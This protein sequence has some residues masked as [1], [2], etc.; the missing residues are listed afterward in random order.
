MLDPTG[1]EALLRAGNMDRFTHLTIQPLRLSTNG[2]PLAQESR[3]RRKS[4]V[5]SHRF[6]FHGFCRQ[7]SSPPEILDHEDDEIVCIGIFPKQEPAETLAS[8]AITS[9][10]TF[11]VF[12]NLFPLSPQSRQ[13]L[14][15]T[16]TKNTVCQSQ[17]CSSSTSPV[18]DVVNDFVDSSNDHSDDSVSLKRSRLRG[19]LFAL[20][21]EYE[22]IENPKECPTSSALVTEQQL[23][24][25]NDSLSLSPSSSQELAEIETRQEK[26]R[27]KLKITFKDFR[28]NKCSCDG[29]TTRRGHSSECPRIN[30]RK[31]VEEPEE[32]LEVIELVDPSDSEGDLSDCSSTECDAQL[33][34]L[35]QNLETCGESV[36]RQRSSPKIIKTAKRKS[37]QDFF[38]SSSCWELRS[39]LAKQVP[40]MLFRYEE[41]RK[42][43]FRQLNSDIV[44]NANNLL[45]SS[46]SQLDKQ[47]VRANRCFSKLRVMCDPLPESVGSSLIELRKISEPT[48]KE[49]SPE[50]SQGEKYSA[51]LHAVLPNGDQPAGSPTLKA[52]NIKKVIEALIK[53][54]QGKSLLYLSLEAFLSSIIY[55]GKGTKSRSDQHLVDADRFDTFLLEAAMIQAV[56]LRNLT[57]QDER[58]LVPISNSRN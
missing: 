2:E 49:K 58:T 10:T 28:W 8:S 35:D 17:E 34:F 22:S 4:T 26:L 9:E 53:A 11:L 30:K 45:P 27:Q 13:S 32:E 20:S 37:G 29:L 39:Q 43:K 48:V 23:E 36:E 38:H 42:E 44:A 47:S 3:R 31:R 14:Y 52:K 24:N 57:K 25:D 41:C 55:I 33:D 1:C 51:A 16:P 15:T 5:E 46:Y 50:L 7:F 40:E 18:L 12:P 6:S 19:C 21:P 54:K 56:G